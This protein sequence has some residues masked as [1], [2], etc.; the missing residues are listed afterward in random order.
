MG[1][2]VCTN[3]IQHILECSRF[4]TIP[5]GE[6]STHCHRFPNKNWVLQK[7]PAKLI[8]KFC[9]HATN[10]HDFRVFL[11]VRL[12]AVIVTMGFLT[13]LFAVIW[14][15]LLPLPLLLLLLLG[16]YDYYDTTTTATTT[17]TTRAGTTTSATTTKT[18]TTTTT[19]TTILLHLLLL[20]L[21][22]LLPPLLQLLLLL[23]VLLTT[24]TTA[25][26]TSTAAA[27]MKTVLY[28]C[29][30]MYITDPPRCAS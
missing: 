23:Q 14:L 17:T 8:C 27:K 21:L 1:R 12:T 10:N 26:A 3:L 6:A 13:T 22:L 9:N 19:T 11:S 5:E 16:Y 18:T 15:L 30:C 25:T 4:C 24:T 29:K 28:I 20:L 7:P 2:L